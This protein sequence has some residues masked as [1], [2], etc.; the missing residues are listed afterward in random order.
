MQAVFIEPINVWNREKHQK[1]AGQ[2]DFAEAQT[3]QRTVILA[4]KKR[5]KRENRHF[6]HSRLNKFATNHL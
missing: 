3:W 1:K 2:T 4:T 6:L 5:S